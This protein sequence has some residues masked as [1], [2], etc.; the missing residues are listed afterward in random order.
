MNL[1]LDVLW[2]RLFNQKSFEKGNSGDWNDVIEVVRGKKKEYRIFGDSRRGY[3]AT[4]RPVSK[5]EYAKELLSDYLGITCQHPVWYS[6]FR[7]YSH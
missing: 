6:N 1:S 4:V 3:N 5:F 7:Y 2:F